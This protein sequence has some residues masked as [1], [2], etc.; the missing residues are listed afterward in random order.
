MIHTPFLDKYIKDNDNSTVGNADLTEVNA[1]L[2]ELNQK[3]NEV[4][5]NVSVIQLPEYLIVNKQN[6]LTSVVPING[7]QTP[8]ITGNVLIDTII[9]LQENSGI[10]EEDLNTK[11][12]KQEL[13][14]NELEMRL[15]VES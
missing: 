8:V 10:L 6:N 7:I 1:K 5:N 12:Q 11:I 15:G 4:S 14:I 3:L 9:L 2:N 13:R